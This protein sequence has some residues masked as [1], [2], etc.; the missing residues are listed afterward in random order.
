MAVSPPRGV[1]W[2]PDLDTI[3]AHDA[4][5]GSQP[6][7]SVQCGEK[8]IQQFMMRLS[9]NLRRHRW[10]VFACWLLALLPSIYLAM[11]QSNQLTGGGFEVAGSQ[12][13]H[14]QRQLEEHYAQQGASPLA[15]VAAPLRS[16]TN[17]QSA[18]HEG[19]GACAAI[20]HS[21]RI[22]GC[23]IPSSCLR[24][25]SSEKTFLRKNSRP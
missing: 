5:V 15:L 16:D 12:S 14:V 3:G 11:T 4:A 25:S 10:L 7:N 1:E 23:R 17:K 18:P 20:V 13:L 8:T 19:G 9:G 21:R 22:S 2:V 24:A 6:R